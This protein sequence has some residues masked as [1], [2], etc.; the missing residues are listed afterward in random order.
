MPAHAL[1]A[2]GHAVAGATGTVISTTATYPLDLVTTRL[3]VQ[4]Q[5]RKENVSGSGHYRGVLH[6]IKVITANEGGISALYVGLAQDVF[7][8]IA[9]SFLF[10][11]F[12]AYFRDAR[13]R[14]YRGKLPA[15]EALAVGALAGACAR[16]CTTP[17]ANVVTRK[18]T[19][20]MLEHRDDNSGSSVLDSL[21]TMR[22]DNGIVGLWAGYSASLLLTIN[23]S[24]TF[25]L[26]DKLDKSLLPDTDEGAHSTSTTFLLAAISKAIA[27]M[28]SYPLQTAKA[29]LQVQ[30]SNNT[31]PRSS[32]DNRNDLS[33]PAIAGQDSSFRGT[34]RG[35]ID[36]SVPA[37]VISIAKMEGIAALYAG[38]HGEILKSFFS[39]GLTM[40]SKG[41]IH[42]LVT[43]F[44]IFL[45]MMAQRKSPGAKLQ[46]ARHL[47]QKV[48]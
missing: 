43:R 47:L 31:P 36:N 5:L 18:Q 21:R 17:I 46:L 39:H 35:M 33:S 13:R 22:K 38:L 12:Y 40:V 9:D 27:T 29:R 37:L 26:N 42:K 3:K 34:F 8:S 6:A 1:V 16:A 2:L 41:I 45:M 11:L 48:F 44:G 32:T 20:A 30:G 23:P 10:F 4:R 19:L 24:I 28:I 15:F 25:F 7:K 14:S